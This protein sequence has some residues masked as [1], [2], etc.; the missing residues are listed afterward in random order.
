MNISIISVGKI[1]EKFIAEAI[2]EFLKRLTPFATVKIKEIPAEKLRNEFDE[3]RAREIEG[4]KILELLNEDDFNIG[5]FVEGKQLSSVELSQKI[6]ELA[7]RGINKINFIIG[8]ATGLDEKINKIVNFKL[9]FSKMTFPHQLM[10]VILLEQI[11]RAFKIINNE[12]Y[13]K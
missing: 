1:R 5:L 7:D 13:H 3:K 11:Y 2:N 4:E 10:R 8:G 12:P 6:K 9:S